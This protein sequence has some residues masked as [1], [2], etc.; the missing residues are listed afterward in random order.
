MFYSVKMHS[1][2][3]GFHGNGGHHISGAERIIHEK[4]MDL[5]VLRMI[6][7]ARTHERG[8]ADF[9]QIKVEE[10][11]EDCIRYYPILLIQETSAGTPEEGRK[12]AVEELERAGVSKKAVREGFSRLTALKDSM[13]GAMVLDA[14]EGRR[15]DT[16]GEHG[17]RCSCMDC[18]DHGKYEDFL[19]S[20]GLA[21]IHVREALILASKVAAASG[22][23]AELCWSDDPDYVT[24]YVAS[25]RRGYFRIP[26]MKSS[27]DGIG[28]R[29]FFVEPGTDMSFIED[30]MENQPVLVRCSL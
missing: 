13:R 11:P 10:L 19:C 28:G 18:E 1:S 16:S 15:L 23:V 8:C 27:G 4:Q 9:I 12:K 29:I 3:G 30:Y 2:R 7:R 24:G 25:P 6:H 17:I 22:M 26:K 20:R 5:S 21:G 14:E